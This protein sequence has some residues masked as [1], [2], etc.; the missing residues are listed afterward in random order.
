MKLVKAFL[1]KEDA[2]DTKIKESRDGVEILEWLWINQDFITK[3]DFNKILESLEKKLNSKAIRKYFT[4][5]EPDS[6]FENLTRVQKNKLLNIFYEK[7]FKFKDLEKIHF[8][9]LDD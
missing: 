4:I 8:G 1:E 5:N 6:L 9:E 2:L 7:G 3:E